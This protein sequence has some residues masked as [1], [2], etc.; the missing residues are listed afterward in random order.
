[1]KNENDEERTLAISPGKRGTYDLRPRPGSSPGGVGRRT[2]S[3][4]EFGTRARTRPQGQPEAHR[5]HRPA[6]R[7]WPEIHAEC[8][9][10]D[11]SP[12]G[13][14]GPCT[15]RAPTTMK[16]N[17]PTCGQDVGIS[18]GGEPSVPGQRARGR[19]TTIQEPVH[20]PLNAGL[21]ALSQRFRQA[22]MH[23]RQLAR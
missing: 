12:R 19:R 23:C 20:P 9:Y 16:E 17:G 18:T 4:S 15:G 1:M 7:M 2:P 5:D 21:P 8:A 13:P 14:I 22:Q 10:H 6:R 3:R 11:H